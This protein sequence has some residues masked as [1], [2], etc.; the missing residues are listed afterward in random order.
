MTK[1]E[2]RVKA[3]ELAIEYNSTLSTKKLIERA[4]EFEEHLNRQ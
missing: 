4:K 2:L 3:L 1:E